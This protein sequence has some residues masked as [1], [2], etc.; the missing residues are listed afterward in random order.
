MVCELGNNEQ[1]AQVLTVWIQAIHAH[2]NA[3]NVFRQTMTSRPWKFLCLRVL[4]PH[5]KCNKQNESEYNCTLIA[6]PGPSVAPYTYAPLQGWWLRDATLHAMIAPSGYLSSCCLLAQSDLWLLT[7]TKH[8][9]QHNCHSSFAF[10]R[11]T[12]LWALEMVVIWWLH[13]VSDSL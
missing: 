7:L 8:F 12:V 9:P 5:S 2:C 6:S 10:P 1:Q 13:Q 4:L 3:L 11:T